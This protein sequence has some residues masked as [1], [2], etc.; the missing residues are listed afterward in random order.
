MINRPW[1]KISTEDIR[2]LVDEKIPESHTLDYKQELPNDSP[3]SGLDFL[4]DVS[5][6]ANASG[7]DLIFGIKEKREEGKPTAIPEAFLELRKRGSWDLIRTGIEPVLSV[8]INHF[9]GL[10]KGP[11]VIVRAP[12]SWA[13]PHMVT[14][15]ARDY[16]KPQFHKRH[17]GGNHPM[18]IDEIR[19][20]F[21]VSENRIERL[22]R[23][24]TERVSLISSMDESIPNLLTTR[25]RLVTHL[26]PMSAFE[27]TAT[28]DIS[29]L[30]TRRWGPSTAFPPNRPRSNHFNFEGYLIR[31]FVVEDS[32]V[33]SYTQIFRTGVIE[34]VVVLRAEGN[35]D[36][37]FELFAIKRVRDLLKVQQDLE[38]QAPVIV[39]FTLIGLKI[40]RIL[41]IETYYLSLNA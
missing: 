6:F 32:K 26:L 31:D 28:V 38:V 20:A 14:R 19:A 7:G 13:A 22:R 36:N 15:Y 5:A 35:I 40:H 37:L 23:F 34:S 39:M 41:S 27:T 12:A 33:Y 11:V 25:A 17:N 24:K 29:R 2:S 1:N 21:A 4:F 3:Q 18:N 9:E 8:K 10:P 30:D 16:L